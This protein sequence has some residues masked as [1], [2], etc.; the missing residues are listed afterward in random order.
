MP[1]GDEEERM[2]GPLFR[3]RWFVNNTEISH[4]EEWRFYGVTLTVCGPWAVL[5][6]L[7]NLPNFHVDYYLT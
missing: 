4:E 5:K 1:A 3:S 2:L 6:S 7:G